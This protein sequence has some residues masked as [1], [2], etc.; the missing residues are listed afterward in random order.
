MELK[1]IQ[2]KIKIFNNTLNLNTNIESR[3]IDLNSELG[4][5]SKEILKGS[6]YGKTSFSKTG[7]FDDELGDVFYSLICLANLGESDLEACL[8]K[9]LNKYQKRFAKNMSISSSK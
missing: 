3:M 5:L 7:D 4:E 1:D 6:D 8:T 9:A 2:E